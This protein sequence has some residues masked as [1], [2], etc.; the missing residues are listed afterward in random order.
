MSIPEYQGFLIVRLGGLHTALKFIEVIGNNVQSSDLPD[1]CFER[2]LMG[3]KTAVKVLAGKPFD[4]GVRVHKI[5]FQAM[6]MI[7]LPQF[8]DFMADKN[9]NLNTELLEKTHNSITEDLITTLE[10]EEFEKVREDF[11][12][13][14]SSFGGILACGQHP[15]DV[16]SCS[17]R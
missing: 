8:L 11:L 3:P 4:K 16:H 12:K 13:E 1:A 10:Q 7:L 15:A 9:P 2:N 14:T 6:W 17:E 5:T